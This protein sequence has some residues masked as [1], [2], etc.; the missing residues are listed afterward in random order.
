MCVSD[1]LVEFPS[2][3]CVCGCVCVSCLVVCVCGCMLVMCVC[4][5]VCVC[6]CVCVCVCVFG[7][8]GW[9]ISTPIGPS[10]WAPPISDSTYRFA[11]ANTTAHRNGGHTCHNCCCVNLRTSV[12]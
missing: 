6:L 1:E 9:G 3:A 12:L 4:V 10:S 5:C 11:S 2:M 7:W 8:R